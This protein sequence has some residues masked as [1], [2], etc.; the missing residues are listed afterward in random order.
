MGFMIDIEN[1]KVLK[2]LNMSV[3]VSSLTDAIL[4]QI[5]KAD[6]YFLDRRK[7]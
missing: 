3:C 5:F 6:I 4:F 7:L 1:G 2:S